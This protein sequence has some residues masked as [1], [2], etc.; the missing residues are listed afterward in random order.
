M[1]TIFDQQKNNFDFLRL[2]LSTLVIF[3]HSYPLATGSEVAEPFNLLT[4]NQVTGGHIAVDLFF[5]ISGFLITASFERS[6]N[7]RDYLKKRIYRIYPAFIVVML[8]EVIFVLPASGGH[9]V[10][11]STFSRVWDFCLQTLRLQEFHHE[12]AFSGNPAI[13]GTINGSLWSIPYEFWCYI[14]V[15]ILGMTGLLRSNRLL[16]GIFASSLL[17]SILFAIFQ[18]SPGGSYLGVI[19]GYP[20]F[21]ARLLPMYLAGVVLYRLRGHLTLRLSWIVASVVALIV[22]ALVPYGWTILF[23]IAGSFLVLV[24]AF[25]PALPLHG[26]SRHGDFSYG[27]YLYAFPI[28]QLT[29]RFIGHPTSPVLL[30]FMALPM[31]LVCAFMSWHCVEKWFLK[32]STHSRRAPVEVLSGS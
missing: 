12:G 20:P 2:F 5:I 8:L 27:V 11:A 25:H 31:S 26:W 4:R 16:V 9:M 23:P 29:M 3:S 7:L 15:A 19:F 24:I 18:W 6:K 17:L 14:G 21:W 13:G 22:A 10:G 1:Q 30:F 28:Q 32:R